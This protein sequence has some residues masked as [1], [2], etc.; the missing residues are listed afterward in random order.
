MSVLWGSV[1]MMKPGVEAQSLTPQDKPSGAQVW[2][3]SRA[4]E[5]S[6][7]A[8]R[9]SITWQAFWL[10]LCSGS[11]SCPSTTTTHHLET[12]KPIFHSAFQRQKRKKLLGQQ[13][14][15]FPRHPVPN[16]LFWKIQMGTK[17]RAFPS[18]LCSVLLIK[19]EMTDTL[20]RVRI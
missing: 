9:A 15:A 19:G 7:G 13:I 14:S 4:L 6:S 3:W 8:G 2:Q 10:Q 12:T 17:W 1:A 18:P 20:H 5:Q 11:W 16:H